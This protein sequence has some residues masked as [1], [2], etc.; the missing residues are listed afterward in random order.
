MWIISNLLKGTLDTNLFYV[1]HKYI[2]AYFKPT[3][4]KINLKQLTRFTI[5]LKIMSKISKE[6]AYQIR[7]N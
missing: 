2:Y 4:Y 6:E 1:F 7:I 3:F 5:N